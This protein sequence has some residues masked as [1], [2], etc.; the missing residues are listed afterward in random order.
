MSEIAFP[1][2]V[3]SED[4]DLSGR[5]HHIFLA[6]LELHRSTS[7]PVG[8]DALSR[9]PGIRWSPAGIRSTLAELEALGMLHRGHAS[10]GRVPTPAGYAFHVRREVEPSPLPADLLREVD[11]RLR[12][13]SRDVEALLAEASR[14]LSQLTGQLGLAVAAAFEQECLTQVELQALGPTRA[15]MVLGLGGGAVHTL[16]LPLEHALSE[17][18]LDEAV[19]ALRA[20]LVGLSLGEVRL[21]LST[22]P[23]LVEDAAVRI[24]CRAA[25][26]GW[27]RTGAAWFS[28][29]AGSFAT[30]PEFADRER[31]GSLL[32]VLESGP[33]LDRLMVEAAEGQAA[34]RVALDQDRA[35]AGLSLVSFA[36]PGRQGAGLGVLGP[37][38]MDYARCLA[39]VD[40]VGARVADF[41]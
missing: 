18:E 33:P 6:L 2:G 5:Q 9:L 11:E 37:L 4:P 12:R 7:H 13:A 41:I 27:G 14:M 35:L 34:V 28:A 24:V 19:E 17:E 39:V 32:R 29:G 30:Q 25:V 16:V 8:S 31:L 10:A 40:A 23:E 21:R 15:L 20:R 26:A 1:G 3:R 38:R 22:D 36:V